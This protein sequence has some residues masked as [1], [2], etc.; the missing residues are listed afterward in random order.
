MILDKSLAAL[1]PSSLHD[2][3]TLLFQVLS[4]HALHAMSLVAAAAAW[5][6]DEVR[7]LGRIVSS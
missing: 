6:N 3:M 1:S 7:F 4:L 5:L 2:L